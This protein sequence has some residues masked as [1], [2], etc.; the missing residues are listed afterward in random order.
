[1]KGF[2]SITITALGL[3]LLT[4]CSESDVNTGAAEPK[5]ATTAKAEAPKE[6]GKRFNAN[7]SITA[8]GMIVNIAEVKITDSAISVG[9]NLEN[10]A[11]GTLSFY[12]DQGQLVVGDMQLDAN[13]F[14]TSGDIGGEV[15]AGVKQDAVIE[16]LAPDGKTLDPAA[17][18]E[19]KLNFGDVM[20]E[21]FM[22][23]E[24]VVFTV[25]VKEG[26]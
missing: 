10:T 15:M 5:Q 22:T 4:G 1:M 2:K 8:A 3:A 12:P 16:F 24:P 23:S 21:D 13:M 18:T 7:Q 19:L 6:E 14:M 20:T 11:E 17:I 26:K 9:V 25:P